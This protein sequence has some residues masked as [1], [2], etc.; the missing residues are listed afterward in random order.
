M[1][2]LN[3]YPGRE[4]PFFLSIGSLKMTSCS[5]RKTRL[6]LGRDRKPLSCSATEK[7]SCCSSLPWAVIFPWY[8][9]KHKHNKQRKQLECG[10]HGWNSWHVL[11]TLK[12]GLRSWDIPQNLVDAP[13][14]S[15]H[16]SALEQ[17]TLPRQL[18]EKRRKCVVLT[19]NTN[20]N[21]K[22]YTQAWRYPPPSRLCPS[23]L[24]CNTSGSP[25]QIQTAWSW[26]NPGLLLSMMETSGGVFMCAEL[27]LRL[28]AKGQCF[29]LA[30]LL[31]QGCHFMIILKVF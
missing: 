2:F 22:P 24:W 29:I 3:M 13:H 12:N 14:S 9:R 15:C 8:N 18:S 10:F 11:E 16:C 30:K 20:K 7:V 31:H 26:S 5:N 23:R 6:S 19:E 27:T 4:K 25:A 17:S 1:L 21:M 28:N